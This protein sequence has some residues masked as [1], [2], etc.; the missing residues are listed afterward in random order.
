[1]NLN[2]DRFIYILRSTVPVTELPRRTELE[3]VRQRRALTLARLLVR[4][5]GSLEGSETFSDHPHAVSAACVAN[6]GGGCRV[7]QLLWSGVATTGPSAAA[8]I[9]CLLPN[10]A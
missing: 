7:V 2:L 10:P 3:G 8:S 5:S 4:G 6:L 1:M 9:C